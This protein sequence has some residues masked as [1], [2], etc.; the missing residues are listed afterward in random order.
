ML[1]GLREIAHAEP[2][3]S[4]RHAHTG[5]GERRVTKPFIDMGFGGGNGLAD[6]DVAAL[7]HSRIGGAEQ[8][9]VEELGDG[10]GDLGLLAGFDDEG[11]GTGARAE[12]AD[13][14]KEARAVAAESRTNAAA[15]IATRAR[16]RAVNLAS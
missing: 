7:V 11:V 9:V 4:E 13:R 3:A 15:T 5:L 12:L 6:R 2:D 16:F 8:V 1:L 14:E 10:G